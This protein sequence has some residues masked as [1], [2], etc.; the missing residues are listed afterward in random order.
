MF[1]LT[2]SQQKKLNQWLEQ[3]VYPS[4]VS[5]IKLSPDLGLSI[6][7]SADGVEVPYAGAI[8]GDVTYSFTPT[9]LG[10]VIKVESWGRVLDLTEYDMW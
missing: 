1:T 6:F 4:V 2:L 10:T 3:E 5:E 9:S 7:T 8:G